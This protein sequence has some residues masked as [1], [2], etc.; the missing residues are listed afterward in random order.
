MADL[1]FILITLSFVAVCV[2]YVSWCDRIIGPDVW[3]A[4]APADAEP[5]REEVAA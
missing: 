1:L 5:E 2:A 4:E 3:T